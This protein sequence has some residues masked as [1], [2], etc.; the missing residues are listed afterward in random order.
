[1]M[2]TKSMVNVAYDLMLKK[3]KPVTFLKLWEDVATMMGFNK[4]QE[5][6]N[7][8]QFYSDI[9]LDERF[10]SVGDNKWDLRSRHTYNEVVVDT[11]E[12]IIEENEEEIEF[13]EEE[14]V[15]ETIIDD[16][17]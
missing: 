9:S 14:V 12:L 7:I 10:V 17:N 13:E 15:K 8:A 2:S 5:E 11:D 3:R 1:M 4:Q 6:D 16:Y